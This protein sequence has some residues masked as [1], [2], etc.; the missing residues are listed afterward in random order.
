MCILSLYTLARLWHA[1]LMIRQL[2]WQPVSIEP[3]QKEAP[4]LRGLS[5]PF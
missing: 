2:Y 4:H 5:Q 3:K 1:L